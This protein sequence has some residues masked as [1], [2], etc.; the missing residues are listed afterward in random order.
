M[1]FLVE[2]SIEL[3]PALPAD[4][5]GTLAAAELERGRELKAAGAIV[6]I[7]R[8]P[9]APLRNVGVWEAAGATELH[10]LISSLPMFPYMRTNVTALGHHPLDPDSAGRHGVRSSG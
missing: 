9:G 2:I 3:P 7:W 5:R 10:D 8:V 4:E 1:R 6:S